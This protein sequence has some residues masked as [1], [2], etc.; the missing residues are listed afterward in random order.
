MDDAKRIDRV[1]PAPKVFDY[2]KPE[3]FDGPVYAT[4]VAPLRAVVDGVVDHVESPG[5]S[6]YNVPAMR[7]KA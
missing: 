4:T 3:Q 1:S 7:P 5:T 6:M 2:K